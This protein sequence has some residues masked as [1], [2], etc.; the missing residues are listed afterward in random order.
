MAGTVRVTGNDS[1]APPTAG[2]LLVAPGYLA[3]RMYQSYVALWNREVDAVMTGPQFAV[4]TATRAYPGVDQQSLASSVALDTSTMTDIVR[5]L[6]QRG[7]IRRETAPEDGRRR[8]LYLTE[9]GTTRLAEVTQRSL[10]LDQK[11]M[12][13]TSEHRERVLEE[14]RV[15]GANWEALAAS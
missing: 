14:L 11:L 4:L 1:G 13:G 9:A 12:P 10:A 2:P 5:R 8:L 6:E 3:R 7:L 15:L